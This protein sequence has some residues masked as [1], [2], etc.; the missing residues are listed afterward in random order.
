MALQK[1]VTFHGVELP[2]AYHRVVHVANSRARGDSVI[3]VDVFANAP[4]ANGE[5]L[6]TSTVIAAYNPDL[7]VCD[8]YDHLKTLPEYEGAVDV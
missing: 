8:A 2:N 6:Q 1:A 5:S 4:A 3:L 7:T